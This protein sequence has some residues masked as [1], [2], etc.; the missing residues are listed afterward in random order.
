MQSRQLHPS[1]LLRRLRGEEVRQITV[2]GRRLY[3]VTD[4]VAILTSA[5][6][7][8]LLWAEVKSSHPHLATLVT[9]VVVPAG[10]QSIPGME[11]ACAVDAA[12]FDG[13]MRIVQAIP[14]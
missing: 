3:V 13:I 14:G 8:S 12:D 5:T 6:D 11:E 10:Q 1:G 4:V 7:A 9:S 2:E